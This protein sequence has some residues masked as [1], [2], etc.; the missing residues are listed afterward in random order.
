MNVTQRYEWLVAA[1]AA[2]QQSRSCTS[3]ALDEISFLHCKLCYYRCMYRVSAHHQVREN[4]SS[5]IE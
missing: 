2:K 1:H 5:T 4:F 3:Y